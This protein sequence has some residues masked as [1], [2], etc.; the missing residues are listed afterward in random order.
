MMVHVFLNPTSVLN[1]LKFANGCPHDEEKCT[2][3]T[4]QK[5]QILG[6]NIALQYVY[7]CRQNESLCHI[8]SLNQPPHKLRRDFPLYFCQGN[9]KPSFDFF[10][11]SGSTQPSSKKGV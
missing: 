10:S 4:R 8:E 7:C 1:Q 11:S 6:N 5:V 3:N 9:L 2:H